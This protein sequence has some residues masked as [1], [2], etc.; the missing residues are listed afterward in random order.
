MNEYRV[1]LC[2]RISGVTSVNV[3]AKDEETAIMLAQLDHSDII[4]AVIDGE[5]RITTEVEDVVMVI[6]NV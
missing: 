2:F 3:Q 4:T 1:E 5:G 6:E